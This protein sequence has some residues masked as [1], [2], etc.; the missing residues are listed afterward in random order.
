VSIHRDLGEDPVYTFIDSEKFVR[1]LD[2]LFMNALKFSIQPGTI[3]VS[4]K[5]ENHHLLIQIQN[6]GRPI[7]E[8]QEN[9]I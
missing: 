6:E 8:E 2:N 1:A 5:I 3:D 4:L 7:T 9:L